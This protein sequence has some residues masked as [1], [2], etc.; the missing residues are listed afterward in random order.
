MKRGLLATFMFA[1]LLCASM[2][3]LSAESGKVLQNQRGDVAYQLGRGPVVP[4]GA[5]ASVSIDDGAVA[6]TGA[7]SEGAVTLP[8][9]SQVLLGA[10]TRVQLAFFN[11]SQIAT[12]RFVL[13]NGKTRFEVRHPRGALANYT[14]QTQTGQI[15]IRGTTGDIESS[16][17]SMRV[18]VYDLSDPS[19]PVQVTTID[20]R[21]FTLGAGQT[22]FAHY[23]NGVLQVDIDNVSQQAMAVFTNDFGS[24]PPRGGQQKPKGGGGGS[25]SRNNPPAPTKPAPGTGA[26]REYLIALVAIVA[27]IILLAGSFFGRPVFERYV[28]TRQKLGMFPTTRYC[29]RRLAEREID[30]V[31]VGRVL[32]SPQRARTQRNGRKRLWGFIKE[33]SRWLRVV[34]LPDGTVQNAFFDR[35]FKFEDRVRRRD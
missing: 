31:Y 11:Q 29:R 7:G 9:S 34:T 26:R 35:E 8:D 5:S 6:T 24:P 25:G 15:A 14:F 32:E 33:E 27:A 18:N 19:L 21:S 17:G 3:R 30:Q 1:S 20:G 10:N 4:V 2:A 12:A 22:L 16:S 23:V 13:Y 28:R